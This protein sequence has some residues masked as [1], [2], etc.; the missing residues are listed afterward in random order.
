MPVDSL[1]IHIILHA[2]KTQ[3]PLFLKSSTSSNYLFPSKKFILSFL[4]F[5]TLD[6]VSSA[7]KLE[8]KELGLSCTTALNPTPGP[9]KPIPSV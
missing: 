6:Y 7:S 5:A 3:G 4:S 1:N 2:Y 9:D 8:D